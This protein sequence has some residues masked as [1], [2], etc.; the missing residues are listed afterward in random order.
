MSEQMSDQL[1]HDRIHDLSESD[2]CSAVLA[3]RDVRVNIYIYICQTLRRDKSQ[4]TYQKDVRTHLTC[5]S[6]L[7][8]TDDVSE[9]VRTHART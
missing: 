5:L 1:T 9:H 2:K 6:L 7:A 3:R 4:N 8:I